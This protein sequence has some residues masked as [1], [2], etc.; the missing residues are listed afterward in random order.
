MMRN[1][2]APLLFAG[3]A[4]A[5]AVGGV[6][7]Q[8]ASPPPAAGESAKPQLGSF[9]FDTA[10]MDR[11]A[12]PGDDFY[13]YANGTW[14]KNT[15]IPADK[16]NYGMFIALGDLSQQRVRGI[17]DAAGADDA[18]LIGRAYANYLDGAKVEALGL[19]PIQPWLGKIK[20]LKDRKGYSALVAEAAQRGVSGVYGS[21][22]A[23]A[24]YRLP[25]TWPDDQQPDRMILV[26]EQGGTGMPDRDMYLADTPKMAAIRTAY[27][28]HLAK[29]LTLAGETGAEARAQAI[30]EVETEIAK[31]YWNRDDATDSTKTYNK[32]TLAETAQFSTPTLDMAAVLKAWNP[33]ITEVQV[34]MPSATKAAAQILDQAPLQ[35]LKDQLLVRSLDD[36]SAALPDAIEQENFAFY[37]TVMKGAPERAPRWQRGVN[38][39]EEA[40]GEAIGKEYAARY[41]PPEYKVE[42]RGLI[43][44][45]LAAMD[46]RIDN[47]AWMQPETKARAKEKLKGFTV[48]IGHPDQWRDYS[49]LQIDRGDL[50]GN[51]VRANRFNFDY[52]IEKSGQLVRRWEWLMTPQTV[53]AHAHYNQLEIVFPAAFLQ[54]AFY[55]PHADPAVNYGAIGAVI[56][57]EIIHHFD[58]QGAQY[59]EKGQLANWWTPED[60]AAF[61]KATQAM[62]AQAETYEVLPGE[63]MKGEFALGEN[64]GDLAGLTLA[65]DAYRASLGGKP[66]P[67]I[68]GFTGDQRFFLGW[69]QIWRRNYREA[70]LRQRLMTDAHAPSIQRVWVMR[71][72]DAWYDAYG[73][74]PGD[75]LYL[76]PSQRIRVW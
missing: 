65:Y 4:L 17:L 62:V 58:D 29:L 57:H 5:T 18:S 48:K 1:F 11:T 61:T 66:A 59:N 43:D 32:F 76:D 16:A 42:L 2:L 33:A 72:L 27:V 71:N 47:L 34:R 38:F 3:T 31:A 24:G 25:Y 36:L 26:I 40:F 10:G 53:N 20:A 23:W 19:A 12:K 67:V 46:R 7:A 70:D 28:A 50:Y 39:M 69:A 21:S 44:N 63:H 35:V 68:D 75:K 54:P 37:G 8:E 6:S 22:G 52:M 51:M 45:I 13:E 15:P 9:G 64:I 60:K 14:A 74:K 41:F 56:G 73:V 55:D 49:G 30:M